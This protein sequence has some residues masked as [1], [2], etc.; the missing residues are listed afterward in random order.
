MKKVYLSREQRY[1]ISAMHRQGC[2]PK[3]M[4]AA[5]GKDKSVIC[6]ELKRNAN[7]KGAYSFEYAQ[8]M[9][10]LRKERLKKPRKLL[11]PVKK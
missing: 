11:P 2:T 4:A 7:H 3:M 10:E 5:I 6:R 1:T 8:G 9:A